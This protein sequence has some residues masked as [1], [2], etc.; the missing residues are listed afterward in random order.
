MVLPRSV[1]YIE[2]HWTA[3]GTEENKG[4]LVN[5]VKSTCNEIEDLTET[6]PRRERHS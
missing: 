6:I 1:S 2:E 5:Q 4:K 3:K